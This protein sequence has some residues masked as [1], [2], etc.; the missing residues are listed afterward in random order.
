MKVSLKMID[1]ELRLAG[2]F[3]RPFC[4]PS[5][6]MFKFV[7]KMCIKSRGKLIEGLHCEQKYIDRKNSQEKIRV[8][9]YKPLNPSDK[10]LPVILYCHGGGYAL[11]IP[12]LA[13][14]QIKGLLDTRDCI[15]VAPDYRKSM[16]APYPAALDDCYDTL[17]WIKNNTK[18]LGARSDQIMVVGHSAGGGL[19]A[20][21]TL[22]AR[23]KK[24]V[25]I[26]FQMPVCPMIDDRMLGDSAID[27]N[28][29]MWNS[30]LNAFGWD[31]YLKGLKDNNQEIPE[32]AA[33]A[34]A[35]DYTNLP[36]TATYVGDI[37][38]FRDETIAYVANLRAAG[39]PT[40]F[41]LYKGGYHGFD[42]IVPKAKISQQAIEFIHGEFSYAVDNYFAKQ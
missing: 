23:D 18:E 22:L 21:V 31:L 36:P 3:V 4:R 42:A 16:E 32:Y 26:A 7:Q 17:K 40:E 9:I 27:N 28:A 25:N 30:K 33:P 24:E 34:R 1:K 6:T 39:V 13:S 8:C 2:F 38:P 5:L 14:P 20:A 15:V 37:E 35:T 10:P 12:E 41:K 19:T 11:T 29:P